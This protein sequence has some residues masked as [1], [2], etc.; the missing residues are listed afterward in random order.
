MPGTD[1]GQLVRTGKRA[2]GDNENRDHQSQQ[3][4]FSIETPEEL[5]AFYESEVDRLREDVNAAPGQ[6]VAALRHLGIA[7]AEHSDLGDA[8]PPLRE[9][10]RQMDLDSSASYEIESVV[11]VQT[12]ASVLLR[13]RGF[14]AATKLY[15][16]ALVKTQRTRGREHPWALEL[17]NNL[18]CV[19]T[20]AGL[21][22]A[23][24]GRTDES[25]DC[26]DTA[27]TLFERAYKSKLHLFG[28]VH[29][30]TLK[31]RC[32]I[33]M[34]SFLRGEDSGLE[35]DLTIA[36]QS[37]KDSCGP[38]DPDTKLVANHLASIY[39]SVRK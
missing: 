13:S 6:F 15:N 11:Y 23:S 20:A 8:E 38:D 26:F 18:A 34:V 19:H 25:K 30:T 24:Q 7:L 14:G 32:N 28:P 27:Q 17:Q 1:S 10:R 36:L 39:Q 31:A 4:V 9:A 35:T 22:H 37:L 12:L 3:S 16:D 5:I 29:R 21:W 33:S 2:E